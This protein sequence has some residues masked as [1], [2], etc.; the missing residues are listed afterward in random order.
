MA[1]IISDDIL[2]AQHLDEH[3][4]RIEVATVLYDREVLSLGL[5]A[6]MAGLDRMQFQAALAERGIDLKYTAEDLRQD[7]DTLKKLKLYG[8]DQ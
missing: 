6:R 8:G 2:R 3:T 5:A 4:L 1:I 7:L